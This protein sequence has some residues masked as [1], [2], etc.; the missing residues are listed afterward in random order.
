[1]VGER[2]GGSKYGGDLRTQDV[3]SEIRICWIGKSGNWGI[4]DWRLGYWEIGRLG[5]W[6]DSLISKSPNIQFL[7]P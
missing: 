3:K 4:G 5:D 6:E 2:G 7:I 1:M